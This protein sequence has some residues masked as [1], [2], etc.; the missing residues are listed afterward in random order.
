MKVI[1]QT[2]GK[3]FFLNVF[4]IPSNEVYH[5]TCQCTEEVMGLPS[6]PVTTDHFNQKL[7]KQKQAQS[8]RYQG[9]VSP[10][11]SKFSFSHVLDKKLP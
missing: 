6:C 3:Y 1:R 5:P 8:L 9:R 2:A 11:L 7:P 4:R 10:V